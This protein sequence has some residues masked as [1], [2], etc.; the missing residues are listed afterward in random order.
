[1]NRKIWLLN[2][3]LLALAGTLV[4]QLR[5]HWR[6]TVS[7]QREV[8]AQ[9]PPPKPVI[10]PPPPPAVKTATPGEYIDVAQKTLFS[11][12]R[13]PNPIEDPPPAAPPPPPP[14]PLPP[15]PVYRGQI[16]IGEPV[17]ILSLQGADQKSYRAGEEVGPFK[18]V[19]FDR[20]K[21][22]LEFDGK[23]IERKVA[24]LQP[25]E[26]PPPPPAQNAPAA[27]PV[28]SLSGPAG[29]A[30]PP[31]F[32]N[33]MGGGFRGCAVGDTSPNGTVLQGYKKIIATTAMGQSC[34]WEQIK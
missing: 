28:K 18:L 26:A 17:L 22:T 27:A 9:T 5:A 12:D 34:H 8:L 33:D 7:H 3:A 2:L 6:T 15:M 14:K 25:K 24:E 21:I 11:R 32:G 29:Q 16:A 10:P 1:M 19:A 31:A 30:A 23:Q 20:E 4:W 13:N